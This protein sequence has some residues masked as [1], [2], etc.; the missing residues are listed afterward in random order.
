MS[1]QVDLDVLVRTGLQDPVAIA[2][3]KTLLEDAQIPFFTMDQNPAAC[4]ESGNILLWWSIRVPREREAE[5]REI[6]LTVEQTS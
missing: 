6:L 1:D 4:Q 3:A 2:L 5:A